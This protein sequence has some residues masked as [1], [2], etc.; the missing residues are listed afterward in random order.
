MSINTNTYK[1]GVYVRTEKLLTL[2]EYVKFGRLKAGQCLHIGEVKTRGTGLNQDWI[3]IN[4][5]SIWI[6]DATPYH[7]VSNSDGGFGWNYDSVICQNY[8]VEIREYG[9]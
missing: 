7:T 1:N 5:K 4:T 2:G 6:G 8:V 9:V 3:T